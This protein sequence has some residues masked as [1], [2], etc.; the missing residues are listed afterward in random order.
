[1]PDGG[2]LCIKAK[3]IRLRPENDLRLRKGNYIRIAFKDQGI[4]IPK[5]NINKIFDPYYTT[6]NSG[7]GLGLT[8]TYAVIQRHGGLITVESEKG[9]GTIFY[10]YLPALKKLKDDAQFT[11]K[12]EEFNMLKGKGKILVMDDEKNIRDIS[13]EM[14]NTLG[15]DVQCAADG[16]ETIELYQKAKQSNQPFDIVLMDLTIPGGLGGKETMKKLKIVDPDVKVI[17]SSGYSNDPIIADFSKFGFMGVVTKP[18]GI[19]E[20]SRALHNV[21]TGTEIPYTTPHRFS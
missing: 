14:I 5:D 6:K 9:K 1:M 16:Y 12:I 2:T 13:K 8:M 18:Y 3:N 11:K 4:G 20:L 15:Y 17:I 7:S 19:Q 21:I 10:I